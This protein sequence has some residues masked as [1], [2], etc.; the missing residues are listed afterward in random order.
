MT[1]PICDFIARYNRDG[2]SRLH[3]PGHK[4]KGP[5]GCEGWDITELYGAD[6]LYA[7]SGIILESE[8]NASAL[9]GSRHTFY[10]TGGS[11]QGIKAM[12]YLALLHRREDQDHAI[13]AGR[14]AH[15]AFLHACAL[16]DIQPLWLRPERQDHLC[17]CPITAAGLAR[18]LER[19]A[20]APMAVYITAPDYL[21]SSPDLAALAKVCR[22]YGVPLLVDNAHG[23]YLRFLPASLH[24]LTLGAAMCCDSAHKTLPV[25]T[26]GAYLHVA[27][28]APA[29]YEREARQALA[30]FGSSSPSYLILASLDA[31]NAALAGGLPERLAGCAQRIAR[32]KAD[33]TGRGVPVRAGGEPLKLAIDAAAAGT[34]G[35]ALAE[36]LRDYL[37]EPEFADRDAL[38]L[39][40][41]ADTAKR[42]FQRIEAAFASF[43]PGR[44]R[45][46][47]LPP[48]PGEQAMSLRRALLSPRQTVLLAEAVGRICAASALTCP[49]AIP[50]IL[51]GERVTSAAASYLA[52]MGWKSLSVVRRPKG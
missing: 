11:S 18:A 15:K 25:L 1:T 51:P 29:D 26:G 8:N 10:A 33:L 6:D 13:L 47:L 38:T 50:V 46:A 21:G 45:K 39:M 36:R 31:C 44:A 4:G 20:K 9:F 48:P 41:S 22:S 49:P 5:V 40:F 37:V 3:V 19:A 24:P 34:C 16:L 2:F 7:P 52:H 23:A 12:L 32:L 17:A 35:E 43:H 27:A 14:N 28:D 42:D 30:L